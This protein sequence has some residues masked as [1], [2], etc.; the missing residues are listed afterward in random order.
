[1]II[2][3]VILHII[4]SIF[5]IAVILLQA[6]RG[7]GLS[8]G[9]F[10]GSPESILGT[11]TAS[12]LSRL[13]TAC[14]IL[15]L[16]TCIALNIIETRKSSSLLTKQK[17]ASQ[18]DLAKV[19]KILEETEQANAKEKKVPMQPPSAIPLATSEPEKPAAQ[20][21]TPTAPQE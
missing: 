11:K 8:W 1:M 3:V 7:Q 6:G 15:F 5:L 16:F 12:F 19:S 9:V 21:P 14:A 20:A 13:T 17:I 10:G 18:I 4:V 2:T